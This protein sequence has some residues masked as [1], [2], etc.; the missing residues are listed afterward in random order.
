M[1]DERRH[2]DAVRDCYST[3]SEN[4]YDRYYGPDAAYP[5]VHTEILRGVLLES[6]ARSVLD[7]GCG[8][9][10]F[11]RSLTDL[12]L[13]LYGFDLTPEMVLE[14][15][16]VLPD[17][18]PERIWEGSVIEPES[19]RCPSGDPA[20]F[21]AAVCVGVFPHIPAEIESGV[22]A[23]LRN[24]VVEGGVVAVEARNQLFS[25][26]TLNRY[27]HQ[28]FVEHLIRPDGLREVF[29]AESDRVDEAL[30]GLEE[31]FRMDIP[32]VRSGEGGKPGYDEVLSRTHN[33]IVLREQLIE[34]GFREVKV[35]FY[36]YHALPPMF[37]SAMPE[38]FAR[39]SLAMED[40]TDWRGYFM[41]SAFLIVGRR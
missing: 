12:P 19:F 23:N 37:E 41:A 35:L 20:S 25:L 39:A 18:G 8:P 5:P 3:W 30:Q 14:A 36:H 22:L 9:A 24:A 13:D 21:D 34:A 33:P 1:T 15:R 4:Y 28:F 2:E 38:P 17:L 10:S 7:A 16:R 29:G 6:G 27:S 26:F 40:P 11:L 31:R 32:P